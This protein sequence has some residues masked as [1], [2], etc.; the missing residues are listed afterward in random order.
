[1]NFTHVNKVEAIY[2]RS[3]VS[4]KVER[5]ST[6]TFTRGLS[7][8]ASISFMRVKFT[9]IRTEKLR[10]SANLFLLSRARRK[11]QSNKTRERRA[12]CA[13]PTKGKVTSYRVFRLVFL[14][15]LIFSLL[16]TWLPRSMPT[17]VFFFCLARPRGTFIAAAIIKATG[18]LRIN[19]SLGILFWLAPTLRQSNVQIFCTAKYACRPRGLP[20]TRNQWIQS[21]KSQLFETGIQQGPIEQNFYKC[22]FQV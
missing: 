2:G 10:Y 16:S 9:C 20:S 8:I 11:T 14:S 13:R 21:L 3:R 18:K 6:F 22:N 17:F 19:L 7:Y 12:Q 15:Y 5:G 4:V 1:M